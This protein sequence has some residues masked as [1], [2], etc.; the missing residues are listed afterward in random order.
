MTQ[1][2]KPQEFSKF[3]AEE[4]IKW[5]KLVKLANASIE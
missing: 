3:I 1:P 5:E 4:S 2:M